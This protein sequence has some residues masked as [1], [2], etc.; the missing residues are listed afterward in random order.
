MLFCALLNS[1]VT[2]LALV[3]DW[4]SWPPMTLATP[5]E[6]RRLTD[7]ITR[8]EARAARAQS[9]RTGR[10]ASGYAGAEYG[11]EPGFTEGTDAAA[12]VARRRTEDIRRQ[13]LEQNILDPIERM[14]Q[15]QMR[16]A[17]NALIQ[18]TGPEARAVAEQ[19]RGLAHLRL[20]CLLY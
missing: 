10:E 18:G 12:Q 19:M 1:S 5:A 6:E 11:I 20:D 7:L 13:V 15:A 14:F 9:F 17:E 2:S 8:L 4:M 3:M 16:E